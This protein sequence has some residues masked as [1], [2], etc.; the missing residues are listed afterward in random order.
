MKLKKILG[1][2]SLSLFAAVSV[3]AGVALQKKA[4][5]VP[6]KADGDPWHTQF[7]ANMTAIETSESWTGVNMSILKVKVWK[8]G[9][10]GDTV[11]FFDMHQTGREHYYA[12][13]AVF[14]GDYSYDMAQFFFQQNSEDKY[15]IVKNS[16]Q[17]SESNYG[18]VYIRCLEEWNVE[19]GGWD[20]VYHSY[21]EPYFTFGPNGHT[22]SYNFT[23]DYSNGEMS[24]KNLVV[25]PVEI[26]ETTYSVSNQYFSLS[27][28]YG[29]YWEF[30]GNILTDSSI[31]NCVGSYGAAWL[32]FKEAGTYDIYLH[33]YFYDG[34]VLEIK[35]HESSSDSFIYYVLENNIPTNDY[36]YTW[37]AKEQFGAWPGT[38]ITDIEG[39]EEVTGDG[40][41]HFEGSETPKLIYKIPVTIGGYPDGDT[42]FKFNNGKYDYEEGY[43]ASDEGT[44]VSEAAYWYTAVANTD[45][46][47][48]ID[49]LIVA[50][51][52]RNSA[53][54]FSVCNID[55][56]SSKYL[57]D[58]YN[59]YTDEIRAYINSSKVYTYTTSEA[60]ELAP[61]GLVSYRDVMIQLGKKGGVTPV[62]LE[63]YF[64]GFD[65]G[66]TDSTLMIV[67]IS[68]ASVTA[69][70]LATLLVIKK[71]KHN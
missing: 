23:V 70:S 19:Q 21:A 62:G 44:L 60:G 3:G 16:S 32:S 5:V 15:S 9:Q 38:R 51:A 61:Q 8:D 4:E 65:F 30:T 40:V 17:S 49:F 45:A 35:K 66:N 14:A 58:L 37:G 6:A 29:D 25:E 7:V 43:W 36:I 55:A 26:E 48:A 33:N 31:T 57:V 52:Y 69:I 41:L 18:S 20:Y 42:S 68:V 63:N 24:Y 64:A 22:S 54:D 28:C 56:A 59:L 67:I 2:I 11:K 53:S 46:G 34:G 71:R 47:E 50:E 13:N 27:L 39:V 10:Y 1:V 12:V